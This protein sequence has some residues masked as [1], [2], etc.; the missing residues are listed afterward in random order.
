MSV[1]IGVLGTVLKVFEKR[2]DELGIGQQIETI[3]TVE[4]N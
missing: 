3:Q 1:A 4:I 2:F